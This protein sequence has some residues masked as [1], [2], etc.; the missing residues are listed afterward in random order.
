[1]SDVESLTIPRLVVA[2]ISSGCGKT[3]IATGLMAAFRKRGLRVQGFKVGPDYID[4]GYHT[5]ATGLA[6]RNLDSWMLG[7]ETVHELFVRNASRANISIIEGVMGLF[8][9][10]GGVDDSGST[11]EV[12]RILQSPVVLALDISRASRSAAA[13][14]LGCLHFDP[15]V[16]I[17][18]VI[19]N[20][21]GS[22]RHYS[23]V[24][25]AIEQKTGLPVLGSLYRAPGLELPERH[26][27]LVPAAEQE[28][29]AEFLE[30]IVPEIEGSIDLKAVQ[31]IG[32]AAPPLR[33]GAAAVFPVPASRDRVSIAVARDEAFSF[34]YQDSLDLLEAHGGDLVYFSPLHDRE[35]PQGI[36]GIYLGGGFPEIYARQLSENGPMLRAV[37]LA[38]SNGMVIYGECGGLMYLAEG[39]VDLQGRRWPMAGL[40]PGWSSMLEKRLKLGYVELKAHGSN[41]LVKEGVTIRG[42]EF[43]YSRLSTPGPSTPAW[44]IIHPESRPEGYRIGNVL[45][46]YIHVHFAANPS[47]APN[48]VAWCGSGKFD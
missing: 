27:G 43:H 39:I 29:P 33:G 8:D 31:Q 42:H 13:I 4:P 46:S 17:R 44:D 48:F 40:I 30:R 7:H 2:G 38:G 36:R 11:A 26:L 32:A 25:E 15:R 1:M 37:H 28:K 41:P 34:Y 16:D 35:L 14:V 20:K 23:W 3:T 5:L 19:L 6:A 24:K 21:A 45:A 12:A 18:G 9:G 22:L 10:H 47:L